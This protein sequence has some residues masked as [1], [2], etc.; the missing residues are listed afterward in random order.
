MSGS[1]RI[2]VVEDC[3]DTRTTLRWMLQAWGHQVA[4]AADG[5]SALCS[6]A[7]FCPDVVLLDIGLP[8][9]NGYE[10]AK[11]L[12][13]LP[14]LA[15]SQLVAVTGFG[16]QDDVKHCFQAGCDTHFLKPYDPLALKRFLSL[17]VPQ[18]TP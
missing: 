11:Q 3:A 4:E 2:L 16:Q 18:T 1:L 17:R 8:G 13:S 14:N 7:S 5:P 9:L 10:V 15:G 12:R 6:A